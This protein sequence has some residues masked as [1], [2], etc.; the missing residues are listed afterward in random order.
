MLFVRA[1]MFPEQ[2]HTTQYK[3]VSLAETYLVR[4]VCLNLYISA[5]GV[6]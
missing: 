1:G 5:C 3:C 6:E 4:V 2:S